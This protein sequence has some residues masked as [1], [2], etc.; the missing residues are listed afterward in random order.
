VTPLQTREVV[1]RG[2]GEWIQDAKE[3]LILGMLATA[4]GVEVKR[5]RLGRTNNNGESERKV[6]SEGS[7]FS[8][9]SLPF[10]ALVSPFSTL[11]GVLTQ[12]SYYMGRDHSG[13]VTQ[14]LGFLGRELLR[15]PL[16]PSACPS[17]LSR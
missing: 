17:S 15:G 12:L 1:V 5:W 4:R 13:P 3:Y 2:C 11:S 9:T 16:T 14:T 7:E 8:C 6:D 10:L